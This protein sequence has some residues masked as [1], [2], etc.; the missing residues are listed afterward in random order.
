MSA[1]RPEVLTPFYRVHP[2][3]VLLYL[4][5]PN[6]VGAPFLVENISQHVVLT[7]IFASLQGEADRAR[8]SS[9]GVW[10]ELTGL[11]R[12]PLVQLGSQGAVLRPESVRPGPLD[13]L[14]A[15]GRGWCTW[16]GTVPAKGGQL[17]G[18]SCSP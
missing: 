18:V 10:S 1:V 16:V 7:N 15:S 8:L 2:V 12:G 11:D 9:K 4:S 13:T 3:T 5:A 6:R 17:P 14:E